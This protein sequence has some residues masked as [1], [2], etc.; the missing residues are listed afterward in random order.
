[1]ERGT[2]G[3]PRGGTNRGRGN[4]RGRKPRQV[5]AEEED[6]EIQQNEK[7]PVREADPEENKIETT[8]TTTTT[9]TTAAI[10]TK[11]PLI[12]TAEEKANMEVAQEVR[13]IIAKCGSCE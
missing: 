3:R 9:T 5:V 2:R 12:E 13:E 6:V 8:T 11:S 7:D 10:T 1:M 4:K